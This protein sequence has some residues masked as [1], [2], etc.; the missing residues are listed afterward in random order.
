MT[1][2]RNVLPLS[3]SVMALIAMLIATSS[4]LPMVTMIVSGDGTSSRAG[5]FE[6]SMIPTP[7]LTT[8][9]GGN[10]WYL[11]EFKSTASFAGVI[12]ATVTGIPSNTNTWFYPPTVDLVA[13]G[14]VKRS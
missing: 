1:G 7:R 5:D 12:T 11:I 14:K 8:G 4:V 3:V 13:N 10:L 9:Q 6:I 2:K